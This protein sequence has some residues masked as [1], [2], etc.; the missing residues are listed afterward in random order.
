MKAATIK[1]M[2]NDELED[3]LT[4]EFE[5]YRKLH[6]N[7]TITSLEDPLVLRKRRRVIARLKTEINQR[8]VK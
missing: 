4:E 5:A 1:E 2:T 6:L 7:H 8:S 3:R